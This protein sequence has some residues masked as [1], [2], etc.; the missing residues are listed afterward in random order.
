MDSTDKVMVGAVC[1]FGIS[2][3]LYYTFFVMSK[4]LIALTFV[5]LF[6]VLVMIL[7]VIA[8][9]KE[10]NKIEAEYKR[11]NDMIDKRFK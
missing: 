7:L 3:A 5:C 1:I 4:G 11:K 6:F 8:G 2:L 9:I 10:H